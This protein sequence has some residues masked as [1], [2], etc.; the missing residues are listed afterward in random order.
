MATLPVVK[1]A[2][3]CFPHLNFSIPDM[4]KEPRIVGLLAL[5]QAQACLNQLG[6]HVTDFLT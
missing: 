6:Y 5:P 1:S 2:F 3:A 4:T